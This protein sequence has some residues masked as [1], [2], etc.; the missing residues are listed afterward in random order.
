MQARR[1]RGATCSAIAA[2]FAW[3][4]AIRRAREDAREDARERAHAQADGAADLS[5]ELAGK[6]AIPTL[7]SLAAK[8]HSGEGLKLALQVRGVRARACVCVCVRACV[9]ARICVRACAHACACVRA[10][11]CVFVCAQPAANRQPIDNLTISA[12]ADLGFFN[13]AKCARACAYMHGPRGLACT[14]GCF[15]AR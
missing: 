14:C 12:A 4:V 6:A 5:F 1:K 7:G 13:Q 15:R 8:L 3:A 10:C 9:R 11:V 2:D